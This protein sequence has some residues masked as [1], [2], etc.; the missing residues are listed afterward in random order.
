MISRVR[1][2]SLSL[3]LSLSLCACDKADPCVEAAGLNLWAELNVGTL[4]VM[5][6]CSPLGARMLD[7]LLLL[8]ASIV[9]QTGSSL[10]PSSLLLDCEN[11]PPFRSV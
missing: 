5:E 11:P 4:T 6:R 2:P 7:V 3:S 10:E 9:S 1:P 8:S